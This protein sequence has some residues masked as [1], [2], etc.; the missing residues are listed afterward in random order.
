MMHL[1]AIRPIIPWCFA[2]DKLNYARYLTY[3]YAQMSRLETDYPAV[4][5]H[6]E[7]GGL[8]VQPN[9]NNPFGKIPVDH[10]IEETINKDTQTAGETRGFSLN[11]GAYYLTSENRSQYLRQLRNI[12]GTNTTGCFSH[13]DLQKTRKEKDRVDVNA[14]VE[15]MKNSWVTLSVQSFHRK[16]CVTRHSQ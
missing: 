15:L 4:H 11:A 13:H 9:G 14:F 1:A 6:I 10:T 8:S 7:E 16:R 12:T 3:Y 5:E 2:Y